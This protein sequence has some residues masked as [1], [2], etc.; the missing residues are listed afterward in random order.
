MDTPS[1]HGER[2]SS[3]EKQAIRISYPGIAA[4]LDRLP[5]GTWHRKVMFLFGGVVFCDCLDMY[6]GGGILAQLLQNG[7]STVDLNAVFASITMIGY[8][9]GALFAGYLGD[10]F[11]RRKSLLFSTMLFSV[12]TFL[13]A[14]APTMETLIVMRGL[15]GVGLGGAL[16]G[17]YGA[18]SGTASPLV[19]GRYASWLGLI[20]KFLAA[21]WCTAHRTR[22]S[23]LRLAGDLH[24]DFAHQLARF[25]SSSGVTC[26]NP[27]VGS[28]QKDDA[29]KQ[30]RSY[31][32][33]NAAFC[34]RASNCPRSIMLR[35]S[36][37][38]SKNP[39]RKQIGFPCSA[40][41]W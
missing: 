17:S 11:G 1:Y 40:S 24:R 10:Q 9:L 5:S 27:H 33:Q 39:L 22:Y 20:R 2:L 32:Q 38:P 6:V 35:C 23:Y 16:P 3:T 36:K 26:P 15:M 28:L 12:M 18:L 37:L 13:A 14:F 4:R 41:A 7:W 25:G 19:R 29:P 30:T 8:L 34:S 31:C 21:T